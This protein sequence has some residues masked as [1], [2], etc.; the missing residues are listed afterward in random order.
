MRIDDVDVLRVEPDAAT[1]ILRD[2]E[3]LGLH[4]DERVVYQSE[5]LPHYDHA[6]E[7]LQ[8]KQM[9]FPCGCSR[10]ELRGRSYPGTCRNGLPSGKRARSIRLRVTQPTLCVD[11]QVQGRFEQDLQEDVGDFVVK[12]GDGLHAY[13]L[14]T[15]VDDALQEITHIV[16][17]A[18]LLES[19][20]RQ[21]LLQQCL[22]YATPRYAHLPVALN[23]QGQKLSKQT[24]AKALDT[25]RPGPELFR[26]LQFLGQTPPS[27][28]AYA[29][30]EELLQWG[31]QHWRLDKVP[32][33]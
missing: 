4:W 20:P 19:T 17:G 12:R 3:R 25:R 15:V 21:M 22:G 27:E 23:A 2:L 16:R 10:R 18:D 29:R 30:P 1:N 8:Q 24:G 5:R 7:L 26:C 28:A 33:P 11:D 31:V 6:L 9:T 13:H 14:A 32:R